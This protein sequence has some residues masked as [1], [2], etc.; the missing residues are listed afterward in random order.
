MGKNN[1]KFYETLEFKKLKQEWDAKLVDSEFEDIEAPESSDIYEPRLK[2]WDHLK[3]RS[4][5]PVVFKAKQDHYQRCCDLLN[6]YPWDN[7][8]HKRIWEL[9]SEGATIREIEKRIKMKKFGRDTIHN[10]IKFYK[11]E[12]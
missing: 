5:D 11:K 3:F 8:V 1:K 2:S 12:I 6:T 9:Y 7:A 10:I 4:I